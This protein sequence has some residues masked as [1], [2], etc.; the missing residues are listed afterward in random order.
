MDI[1]E[2]P[3]PYEVAYAK[4][5][6]AI[7]DATQTSPV[8]VSKAVEKVV[9]G[10]MDFAR[11]RVRKVL[12]EEA[13]ARGVKRLQ[14]KDEVGLSRFIEAGGGICQHQSLFSGALLRLLQERQG[15]Q[16]T[17]SLQWLPPRIGEVAV[18]PERHTWLRHTV[19][20]E[21]IILDNSNSTRVFKLEKPLSP[22]DR[23]YLEPHEISEFFEETEMTMDE[24][25]RAVMRGVGENPFL[26]STQPHI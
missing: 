24:I 16:G 2:V 25:S 8:D 9:D 1:S 12:R 20:G 19:H 17:V 22:T 6:H 21:R 15:L 14:S 3:E 13:D 26:S 11:S 23:I 18:D 10:T 5:E 4:V 7:G